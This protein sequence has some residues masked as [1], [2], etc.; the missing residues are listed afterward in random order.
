MDYFVLLVINI[1]AIEFYKNFGIRRRGRV[2]IRSGRKLLKV[3][4]NKK[5]SEYSKEKYVISYSLIIMKQCINGS[6]FLSI[7]I[8]FVIMIDF[9]YFNII[10]I[11]FSLKGALFSLMVSMVY[12]NF[13]SSTEYE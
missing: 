11:F 7:F 4:T 1:I 12:L 9:F 5:I 3:V 2:L 6:V 10:N 13:K 8:F